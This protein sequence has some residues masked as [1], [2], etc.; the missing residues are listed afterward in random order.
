MRKLKTHKWYW[1]SSQT[2][3]SVCRTT[4]KCSSDNY[5]REKVHIM[6]IHCYKKIIFYPHMKIYGGVRTVFVG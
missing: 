1:F 2:G 3:R 4:V 6:D 5:A